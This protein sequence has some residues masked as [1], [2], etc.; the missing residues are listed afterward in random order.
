M[1]LCVLASGCLSSPT[2]EC[3]DGTVCATGQTCVGSDGQQFCATDAQLAGCND[4]ADGASCNLNGA[5]GV[6]AFGACFVAVCGDGIVGDNEECDG[7]ATTRG[8]TGA[9]LSCRD[10]GYYGNGTV[11]CR[12]DCTIDDTV[13]SQ[14]AAG[15]CGD[16]VVD[17]VAAPGVSELCDGDAIGPTLLSCELR[18]Y[19]AGELACDS[20]CQGVNVDGCLGYCGDGKIDL[21]EECDGADVSGVSCSDFQ[22]SGY[23]SMRCTPQCTLDD[24]ACE[25]IDWTPV[26][27]VTTNATIDDYALAIYTVNDADVWTLTG[28]QGN[29]TRITWWN[30]TRWRSMQEIP[31]PCQSLWATEGYALVGCNDGLHKVDILDTNTKLLDSVSAGIPPITSIWVQPDGLIWLAA[32][33]DAPV[34]DNTTAQLWRGRDTTWEDVSV[35]I[36]GTRQRIQVL[37]GATSVRVLVPSDR[38]LRRD[39]GG[40]YQRNAAD[41]GWEMIGDGGNYSQISAIDDHRI[42]A[43]TITPADPP[44]EPPPPPSTIHYLVDGKDDETLLQPQPSYFDSLT[45][46]QL[47]GVAPDEFVTV[48]RGSQ[49]E[50]FDSMVTWTR[51]GST[52][53]AAPDDF[54]MTQ[55]IF[56]A[57]TNGT[58]WAFANRS[59]AY[60]RSAQGTAVSSLAGRTD[61]KV[62]LV[63]GNSTV[64]YAYQFN[65]GDKPKLWQYDPYVSTETTELLS[66]L[67]DEIES[68]GIVGGAANEQL[69][70]TTRSSEQKR[71]LNLYG[72]GSLTPIIGIDP[73]ALWTDG[74]V[75]YVIS[76]ASSGIRELRRYDSFASLPLV[77]N[78]GAADELFAGSRI[79][80]AS[81][82]LWTAPKVPT[83]HITRIQVAANGTPIS[84]DIA[85][86]EE[87][88][89]NAIWAAG[90]ELWLAGESDG[91]TQQAP[92][93]LRCTNGDCQP[94]VQPPL[95]LDQVHLWT[96]RPGELW[97]ANAISISGG[98]QVATTTLRFD[99][100]RWYVV[101][102]GRYLP[103]A[104]VGSQRP[105]WSWKPGSAPLRIEN[106]DNIVAGGKCPARAELVCAE[107]GHGVDSPPNVVHAAVGGRFGESHYVLHSNYAG[108]IRFTTALPPGVLATWSNAD[109][110]GGCA[111]NGADLRF[112]GLNQTATETKS[113]AAD[114][115]YYLTLRSDNAATEH[116]LTLTYDCHRTD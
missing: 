37:T 74:E 45:F 29:R 78:V 10:I 31:Q 81:T 83:S 89:I 114:R 80:G 16:G 101:N 63:S 35:D 13:C 49:F 67:D 82:T 88:T 94:I 107:R 14:T 87:I 18:N 92:R 61:S 15:R 75:G 99:G 62:H 44:I 17:D 70:A 38:M 77:T 106:R 36:N 73:V 50:P 8:N 108:D 19:Y 26:R 20:D 104:A 60:R 113:L 112:G 48:D 52:P 111:S 110:S 98:D 11:A 69:L 34:P 3:G 115:A 55:N 23:G 93:I 102:D 1:L 79:A 32:S 43:V 47:Q 91:I 100:T 2:V 85:L 84:T 97:I 12:P 109:N 21:G 59:Q 27:V 41:N 22:S 56:H 90:N 65:L 30:G 68:L 4:K 76:Q 24:V 54:R 42:W 72:N 58:A 33:K 105:F 6:C 28:T 116:A 25:N 7:D 95:T 96:D 5:T 103:D 71:A 53:T 9:T 64:T 39:P 40:I 57:K 51:A 46:G 86:H 66:L